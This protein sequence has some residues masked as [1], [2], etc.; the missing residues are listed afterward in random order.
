[1]VVWVIWISEHFT[2]SLSS[3]AAAGTTERR[4]A[5]QELRRP[6]TSLQL[7]GYAHSNQETHLLG[8]V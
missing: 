4:V 7:H 2:T 5:R 8:V 6:P 1:M 3:P